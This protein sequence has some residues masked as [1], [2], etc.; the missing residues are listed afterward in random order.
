LDKDVSKKP[1]GLAALSPERRREIA[2]M[3]GKGVPKDKRT[4]AVYRDV[5]SRAGSAKKP[6]NGNVRADF[7]PLMNVGSVFL[8]GPYLLRVVTSK[9]VYYLVEVHV[10]LDL[11]RVFRLLDKACAGLR[12]HRDEVNFVDVLNKHG[13]SLFKLRNFRK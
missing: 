12:I 4:F 6:T 1:R 2:S 10:R 5:A 13:S 9:Q 7:I 8:S 11:G 3:G